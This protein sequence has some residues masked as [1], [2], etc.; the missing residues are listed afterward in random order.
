M[1]YHKFILFM[2]LSIFLMACTTSK[3]TS[4]T[5]KA[6]K[7]SA[8]FLLQQLENN[9]ID[10]DWF[11]CKSK[12]KFESEKEKAS[13][14]A[15][16][17]IKKDSIIWFRI[18]KMNIEGLRIK[19]TPETIEILNRQESEYMK[20]PFNYLK[21]EFGLE[22]SFS[23]LQELI[24]GNAILH[25]NQDLNSAITDNKNVLKT[26]ETQKSV[27]KIFMNPKSFLLH[28]IRGSMKNNSISIE[29]DEYEDIEKQQIPSKKDV[30]ID[31]EDIGAITVKMTFTKTS[32]NQSQ[33]VGF[34]VPDTYTRVDPPGQ[35]N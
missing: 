2:L 1:P 10:Y 18:K 14:M 25:K 5:V 17:R 33:K 3:V 34:N 35:N 15:D 21:N 12:I 19:V 32:I 28:E 16:I 29:Y 23:E 8:K 27:L 26:P 4:T 7:R 30:Y 24:V 20:A 31:S 9:H 13:F 22:L 6:K 11:G